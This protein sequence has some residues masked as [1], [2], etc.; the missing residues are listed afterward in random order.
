[1]L[2]RPLTRLSTDMFADDDMYGEDDEDDVSQNSKT[3]GGAMRGA[4]AALTILIDSFPTLY[5]HFYVGLWPWR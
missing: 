5:F 4:N 2:F 1:M 3:P